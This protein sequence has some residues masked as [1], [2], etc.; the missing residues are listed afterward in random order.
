MADDAETQT[1]KTIE[2]LLKRLCKLGS[3]KTNKNKKR[4]KTKQSKK[5]NDANI[6]KIYKT[7]PPPP[8]PKKKY[9]NLNKRWKIRQRN[10]DDLVPDL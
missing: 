3:N 6:N 9:E 7:P 10:P 2:Q 5:K 8:S 4:T 1:N